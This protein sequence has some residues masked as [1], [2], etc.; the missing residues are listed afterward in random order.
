M[1]QAGTNR[2]SDTPGRATKLAHS[3][4]LLCESTRQCQSTCKPQ[5]SIQS[6]TSLIL[7]VM[8]TTQSGNGTVRRSNLARQQGLGTEGNN[9]L[10][11]DDE[12]IM[13]IMMMMTIGNG[14]NNDDD[15]VD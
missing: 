8:I 1:V 14:D 15:V 12:M 5:S 7:E 11:K 2:A 3:T 9:N 13:M 4:V 10:I 6:T